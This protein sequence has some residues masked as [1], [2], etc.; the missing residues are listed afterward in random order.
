MPLPPP[1]AAFGVP[2]GELLAPTGS[3]VQIVPGL[4]TCRYLIVKPLSTNLGDVIVLSKSGV[5]VGSG[6]RLKAADTPVTLDLRYDNSSL[7]CQA[8]ANGATLTYI[9]LGGEGD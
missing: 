2:F 5:A 1:N 8:S 6:F 9:G 7:L 3:P 4:T